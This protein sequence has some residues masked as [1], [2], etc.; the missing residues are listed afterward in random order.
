[1]WAASTDV[2]SVILN[3]VDVG[4]WE[5][6][7]GGGDLVWSGR[8][9]PEKAPHLAALAARRAGRALR[10]AGPVLDRGYF[11]QMLAPLLNDDIRYVGHLSHGAMV[12]LFAH[13]AVLLQ[14]PVWE[15]P[16]GLTAAEAMATGTPVVSF[17]RGGIPEVIGDGAGVLVGP[18]DLSG[19]V[20]AIDRAEQLARPAVREHAVDRL[21]I[22]R[23]GLAYTDLYGSL[24]SGEQSVD[25]EGVLGAAA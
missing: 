24:L 13:S 18:D 16:F 2:D 19:L 3:G 8:I 12:D 1:M 25:D 22:D 20:A 4:H 23:M 21:G 10:I 6:G 11:Q 9:V 17:A 15:E 14:T 7:P 5:L